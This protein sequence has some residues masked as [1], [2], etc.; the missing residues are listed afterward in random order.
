M[1]KAKIK[2][3]VVLLGIMLLCVIVSACS[4]QDAPDVVEIDWDE[5]TNPVT[6]EIT[7][8]LTPD[9]T[10]AGETP[11]SSADPSPTPSSGISIEE[12]DGTDDATP[13]PKRTYEEYKAI[14]DEVIG[15]I[16][17]N[18]TKVDYPV[19]K[20]SDNEYYLTHSVEKTSS[21]SGAIFMDS[22]VSASSKHIIL[23]GHNMR[24]SGTMFADINNYANSDFYKNNRTF[25][26]T[27][28]SKEYTY[29]VFAVYNTD[30]DT[31][32]KYM[33]VDFPS[34][35]SFAD[36]MNNTLARMSK[37]SVDTVIEP[38]DQVLTLSTCNHTNYDD[39]RFAVHAVR[40]D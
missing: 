5:P 31:A 1:D 35:Q 25:K 13:A 22:R 3:A 27:F 15:W 18:N 38:G 37:F 28:G 30:K 19:V 9:P 21:K 32:K 20:G 14:N 2:Y 16:K 29:K 24:V 36:Y 12:L 23:F 39:G 33:V 8:G 10:V 11:D 34:D 17:I 40:V 4:G 26:V 6:S 7:N